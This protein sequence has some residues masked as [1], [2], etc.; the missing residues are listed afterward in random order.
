MTIFLV[1]CTSTCCSSADGCTLVVVVAIVSL[2]H[3]YTVEERRRPPPCDRCFWTGP[4]TSAGQKESILRLAFAVIVIINNNGT[5]I[6]S[7]DH[8]FFSGMSKSVVV[9]FVTVFPG[10]K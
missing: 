9:L 8:D 6:S 7:C 3:Y 1:Y 4:G 10:V 2:L 5:V